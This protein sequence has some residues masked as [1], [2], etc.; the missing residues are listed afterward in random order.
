MA[1]LPNE[2]RAT[3]GRL[4]P[5]GPMLQ[6][7]TVL[8]ILPVAVPALN[9]MVQLLV[10]VHEPRT[11]EFVIVLFDASLK[12][13]MVEA[14]FVALRFEIVSVLPP[15][16]RPSMVTLSAPLRPIIEPATVPEMILATPPLG[17]IVKVVHAP[18]FRKLV[19]ASAN[20]LPVIVMIIL[21]PVWGVPFIARKA[22]AALEREVYVPLAPVEPA[23][24]TCA[25]SFALNKSAERKK[26][27]ILITGTKVRFSVKCMV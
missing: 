21:F 22:P 8:P 2:P 9:K 3:A 18:A 25:L 19:P 16:F 20:E 4:A 24:V 6:L 11:V 10:V 12:K 27:S 15:V 23:T 17:L 5:A 1:P 14:V 26:H 7:L 13:T